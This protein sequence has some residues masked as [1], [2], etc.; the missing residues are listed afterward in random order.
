MTGRAGPCPREFVTLLFSVFLLSCAAPADA[1]DAGVRIGY[2]K[3]SGAAGPEPSVGLY[4]RIDLPGP[5]NLE[6]AGDIWKEERSGGAVEAKNLPLQATAL[7]YPLPSVMVKPYLLGGAGIFLVRTTVTE[8]PGQ[9]RERDDHLFS[10]HG[11]AG[12][13]MPLAGVAGLMTE[14]RYY[15]CEELSTGGAGGMPEETY[16][17]GGWRLFAGLHLSF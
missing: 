16:R 12:L 17:P 13:E 4:G 15:L 9:G 1:W 10:L 14:F 2:G 3:S 7:L 8:A 5:V 6:L 11:G